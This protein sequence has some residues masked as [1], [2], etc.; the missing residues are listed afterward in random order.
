MGLFGTFT[1]SNGQWRGSPQGVSYLRVD[2]HDSDIAT[3]DFAPAVAGRGRFF[4]GFQPR[5][6]FEDTAASD[7]V[8]NDAEAEAFVDWATETLGAEVSVDQIRFL[9]ADDGVEEPNDAFVED[10]VRT[11]LSA[12]GL[13]LPSDLAR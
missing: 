10:T 3:V 11:L 12:I 9:L 8:D 2:I 7:P 6:Y 13:P 4:L 1:Y 5:D